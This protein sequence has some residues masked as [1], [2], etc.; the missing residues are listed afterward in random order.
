MLKEFNATIELEST[1]DTKV[2]ISV[3][4]DCI[5]FD[6]RERSQSV[7]FNQ[8]DFLNL[9]ESVQTLMDAKRSMQNPNSIF[10]RGYSD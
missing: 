3:Y 2:T 7:T 6:D 5:E 9:I 4:D 8:K 1:E 10:T